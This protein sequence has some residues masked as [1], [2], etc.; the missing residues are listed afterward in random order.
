MRLQQFVTGSVSDCYE[1]RLDSL[2]YCCTHLNILEFSFS[3]RCE[4]PK[5]SVSSSTSLVI[6]VM[7]LINSVR[8][9][10]YFG[11]KKKKVVS[12]FNSTTRAKRR[13]D[14]VFRKKGDHLAHLIWFL[15]ACDL[16]GDSVY[17]HNNTPEF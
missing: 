2:I 10:L 5:S 17:L 7:M 15:T 16:V 11:H 4:H 9:W 12:S 8:M 6:P 1:K 14:N 3:S 13:R